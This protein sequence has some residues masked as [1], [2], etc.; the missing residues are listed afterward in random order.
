MFVKFLSSTNDQ[1]A[2]NAVKGLTNSARERK[3]SKKYSFIKSITLIS[4]TELISEEIK[5]VG[6]AG[7]VTLLKRVKTSAEKTSVLKFAVNSIH[8]GMLL[9]HNR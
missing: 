7:A 3:S 9:C 6:V 8:N 2:I 5:R 4:I 1:L